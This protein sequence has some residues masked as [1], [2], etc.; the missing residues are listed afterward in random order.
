MSNCGSRVISVLFPPLGVLMNSGCTADLV[1]NVALT[2]L[3]YFPGLIHACY[4]IDQSSIQRYQPAPVFGHFAGPH[5]T[6][7]IINPSSPP[8]A[9]VSE[10]FNSSTPPPSKNPNAAQ[11]T[12]I[13]DDLPPPKYD[14]LN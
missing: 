13:P 7:Y 10:S 1:I 14:S 6:I 8:D 3:G 11:R 4:I 9:T 5:Q 12:E 2:T